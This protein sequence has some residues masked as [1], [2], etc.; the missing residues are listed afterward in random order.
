[1]WRRSLQRGWRSEHKIRKF[2]NSF[3]HTSRSLSHSGT[4]P[5]LS[6]PHNRDNDLE[7]TITPKAS[8]GKR[9][10]AKTPTSAKEKKV[11]KKNGGT[12]SSSNGKKSGDGGRQLDLT[13]M[14]GKA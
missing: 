12:V 1:M 4:S 8:R 9:K 10:A 13:K 7:T 6:S 5:S 11:S 2:H 3:T 14:F